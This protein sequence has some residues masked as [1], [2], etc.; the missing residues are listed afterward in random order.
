MKKAKKARHPMQPVVMVDGVARFKENKIVRYILDHGNI[1]LNNLPP[2]AFK[3]REWEQFYQLIGYSVSGYG[4]L[5]LVSDRSYESADRLAREAQ[6]RG[7][8]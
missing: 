8:A 3:R 6:R 2:H 5:T 4:D 7:H 1:T